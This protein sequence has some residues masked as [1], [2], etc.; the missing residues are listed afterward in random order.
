MTR[1]FV[2]A[3]L[4]FA[5]VFGSVALAAPT[6]S[7]TLFEH[8]DFQGRS[9]TTSEAVVD[10]GGTGLND[11]VSSVKVVPGQRWLL[12]KNKKFRGGCIV[13]DRDISDL[14][15]L[16]FNDRISSLRPVD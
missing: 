6:Y 1:V 3:A 9:L 10:L 8:K 16:D 2:F 5:T 14:A 4:F 7:I 11:A 13:V 15:P 12:C